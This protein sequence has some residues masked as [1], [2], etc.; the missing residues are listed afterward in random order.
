MSSCRQNP[1]AS[2]K[3]KVSGDGLGS[4]SMVFI[5]FIFSQVPAGLR[6]GSH[7]AYSNFPDIYIRFLWPD[8]RIHEYVNLS[9]TWAATANF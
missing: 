5:Y 9:D 6:P 4:S 1:K 3:S 2:L 7:R 8:D